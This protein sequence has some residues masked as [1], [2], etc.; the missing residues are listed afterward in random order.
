MCSHFHFLEGALLDVVHHA[1]LHERRPVLHAIQLLVDLVGQIPK[2]L[3]CSMICE[4]KIYRPTPWRLSSGRAA[5]SP[6]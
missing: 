3:T 5:S 4:Q 6:S 1:A 2:L